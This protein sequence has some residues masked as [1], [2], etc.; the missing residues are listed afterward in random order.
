MAKLRQPQFDL[1]PVSAFSSSGDGWDNQLSG[2]IV[3]D[4]YF[5]SDGPLFVRLLNGKPVIGGVAPLATIMP[6]GRWS[7]VQSDND[8]T[9]IF[10]DGRLRFGRP[11]II[12]PTT[13]EIGET[14]IGTDTMP[15]SD[16]HAWISGPYLVPADCN[17]DVIYVRQAVGSTGTGDIYGRVFADNGSGFA[18]GAPL[19]GSA[20]VVAGPGAQWIALPVTGLA[21]LIGGTYIHVGFV[22]DGVYSSDY[23]QELGAGIVRRYEGYAGGALPAPSDTTVSTLSAYVLCS[24]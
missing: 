8:P 2:A 1:P 20:A 22:T 21:P 10:Q 12:V 17:A 7:T 5:G 23:N 15:P 16:G 18:T 6:N 14:G 9:I 24:T 3:T 4:E 19:A 11:R 13:F